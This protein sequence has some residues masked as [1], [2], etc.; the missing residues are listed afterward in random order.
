MLTEGGEKIK[1]LVGLKFRKEN[2]RETKKPQ[3]VTIGKEKVNKKE[4]SRKNKK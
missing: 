2:R 4:D 3:E 1:K